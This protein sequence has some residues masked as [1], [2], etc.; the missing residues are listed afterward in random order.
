MRLFTLL[1]AYTA[2]FALVAACAETKTPLVTVL[3]DGCVTASGD[4]FILTDLEPGEAQ[5]G[6]QH[7]PG[8]APRPTTEAYLLIGDNERL[9]TLVGRRARVVGE[10]DPAQVAEIR[11][12]TPM[13]RA[14]AETT[15]AIGTAGGNG[16]PRVS[17]AQEIRLEI[18]R[19]RVTSANL[20]GDSCQAVMLR[21]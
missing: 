13:V 5:E 12:L 19:L 17:T 15:E 11:E 6:L 8:A 14:S 7:Q 20:T 10:A 21:R 3:E 9:R 1:A 18:H 2:P 16:E 4:Q